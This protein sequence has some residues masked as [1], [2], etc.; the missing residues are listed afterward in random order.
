MNDKPKKQPTKRTPEPRRKPSSRQRGSVQTGKKRPSAKQMS[1]PKGRPTAKKATRA[2]ASSQQANISA[3]RKSVSGSHAAPKRSVSQARTARSFKAPQKTSLLSKVT[4]SRPAI[5]AAFVILALV[6]VGIFD[7]AANWGKAYGN[8]TINGINVGG[9]TAGEMEDMLKNEYATRVSHTQ[10]TLYS[11]QEAMDE[12]GRESIDSSDDESVAEQLSYEDTYEPI[13]S[14]QVDSLS[15]KATV[16]YDE[17]AKKALAEGRE[18]GGLLGR[19][20]LLFNKHDVELGVKFDEELL[21]NL[22]SQIDASIGDPRVDATVVIED[23]VARAVEGH[24]GTMADRDWLTSTLSRAMIFGDVPSRLVAQAI[25][26]QSRISMEQAEE[27]ATNVNRAIADGVVFSYNGNTWLAGPSVLGDWTNISIAGEKGS[28]HLE[29]AITSSAAVP[30]VVDKVGAAIT[31]DNMVV[32]FKNDNGA[33]MVHTEGSANVPE[34]S[35]AVNELQSILYGPDGKVW[36]NNPQSPTIEI[37][38]SDRPE[39]LSFDDALNMGIISVIGEFT[40]EFSDVEGTENRNHNIKLAADIL[41][42]GIIESHGGTWSFN[43]RSGDTNEE[44]GFWTAGSIVQGEYVDSVG[45]G[46]CQVATTIF[47]AV[48]EAGLEVPERHNHTLYIASYPTGRDA[49]VDYPSDLDLTWKNGLDSDILLK[50]SYTDTSLTAQLFSV[51]TGYHSDYSLGDWQEGAKYTTVYQTDDSLGEGMYYRKT[52]G[53]DGSKI[54][55]TRSVTDKNGS[56]ILNDAFQSVYEPKDEVYMVG[57]GVDT[58][59]LKQS[60]GG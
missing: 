51:R 22:A 7:T 16:P 53:E 54:T 30:V 9:M 24:R 33:I 20:N 10:V 5:I 17:A 12:A 34:V 57:P 48:L 1:V 21:E 42:N 44:A 40:T 29:P 13:N 56:V 50:M 14:W 38:E 8:V 6:V 55:M 15:L 59:K 45:G 26:E 31:S 3:Q 11:S 46:I 27:M 52:V 37:T 58:S 47:N 18:N 28:W 23:G 25:E 2:S 41:N 60:N 43:D 39:T 19:L 35:A 49:A 4:S 36:S 32:S